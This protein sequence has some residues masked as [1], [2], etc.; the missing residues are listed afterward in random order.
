MMFLRRTSLALPAVARRW[1]S[2]SP[3]KLPEHIKIRM[4]DVDFTQSV[5]G[6]KLLRWFAQEG[7]KIS[8]D[9]PICEVDTPELTFSLES[10]DEGYLAKI[11]VPENSEHVR[12]NQVL[13]VLV[14]KEEEI[15]PF[16]AA[17]KEFPDEIE[18]TS[19]PVAAM[20]APAA[21]PTD[22]SDLLRILST[23]NKEGVF[24]SEEVYKTLKSLARKNDDELLRVFKGSFEEDG[25]GFDKDFFVENCVD[26]VEEKTQ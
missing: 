14:E 2:S 24:P 9:K 16:L 8:T 12:P 26:L 18:G 5:E 23:L 21:D 22:G 6:N 3:S 19:S 25:T 13:A 10:D 1:C 7:S 20:A 11:F 15:A 17:L 4:L